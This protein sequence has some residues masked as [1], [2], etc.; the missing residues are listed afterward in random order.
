MSRSTYYY[1]V[2]KQYHITQKSYSSGQPIVGYSLNTAGKKICDEQIKE[3]IMEAVQDEYK[4][5]F[6]GYRKITKYLR[7]NYNLTIN[8]KKVYR[9]CKEPD[10]LGN[11]RIIKPKVTSKISINGII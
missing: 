10:I 4:A 6:Y 11:Q 8:P 2:S 3:Y 9:L 5:L 1:H 7:S